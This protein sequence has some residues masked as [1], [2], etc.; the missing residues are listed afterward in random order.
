ML[1]LVYLSKVSPFSPGTRGHDSCGGFLSCPFF[2][3]STLQGLSGWRDQTARNQLCYFSARTFLCCFLSRC[4]GGRQMSHPLNLKD[5]QKKETRVQSYFSI[6][7]SDF[8]PDEEGTYWS[9][10]PWSWIQMQGCMGRTQMC[11]SVSSSSLLPPDLDSAC[12]SL[13]HSL[14]NRH[15]WNWWTSSVCDCRLQFMED[16]LTLTVVALFDHSPQLEA[17]I[18]SM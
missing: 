18:W 6:N 14:R 13:S 4:F 15:G 10:Y 12:D 1:G 11:F 5:G 8:V 17:Q 9:C 3:E 2:Q 16:S 7:E